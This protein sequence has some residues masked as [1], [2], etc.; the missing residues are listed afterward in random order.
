MQL[1][2]NDVLLVALIKTYI[3]VFIPH[4]R[5]GVQPTACRPDM[6]YG[7]FMWYFGN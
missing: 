1:E 7:I 3:C 2:V 5:A 4:H 6:A